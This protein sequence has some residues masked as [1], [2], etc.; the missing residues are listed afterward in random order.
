MKELDYFASRSS[1]A[2]LLD[3]YQLH[4]QPFGVTPDP[5]YLYLSSTH[6]RALGSLAYGIEAARGFLVLTAEPGLGKTT[7][8]FLLLKRLE[9]SAR[10]AWVFQAPRDPREFLL[11]LLADLGVEAEGQDLTS[12]EQRVRGV[13]VG[14]A[15]GGRRVVAVIDEAHILQSP[16]FETLVR[17]SDFKASHS[18]SLQVL[19]AGQSEL[20]EKLAQPA[21][22]RFRQQVSIMTRLDPLTAMESDRYIDHRLRM[23]G[24]R[25]DRLFTSDAREVI[26]GWSDGIPRKINNICFNAMLRGYARKRE[27][28]DSSIIK[29]AIADLEWAD[30]EAVPRNSLRSKSTEA[31][32]GELNKTGFARHSSPDAAHIQPRL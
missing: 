26:A 7:L 3:Y 13:V 17:L 21:F 22:A 19:M 29:D 18:G 16:V 11:Y 9:R 12:I 1:G 20:V 5:R 6:R 10:T 4:W 32:E 23:A 2:G 30:S 24:H 8:L 31:R 15:L 25:G 27:S 14:E 28:I